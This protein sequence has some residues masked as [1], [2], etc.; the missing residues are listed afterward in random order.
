ML[1]TMVHVQ[2]KPENVQDFIAATR[3]NHESSVRE[4]G[5]RR[6]DIL[7]SPDDPAR[8]VLYEAYASPEAA[9][10]HKNTPHY[11]KWRDTVAP[12]MAVPRVG[13]PYKGLF[14]SA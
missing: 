3:L 13:I 7:Q 5:N 11:S 4:T 10:A 6:F 12:W 2:V 14:P 8:F 9:A 1:V